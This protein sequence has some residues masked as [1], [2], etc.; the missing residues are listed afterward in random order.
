METSILKVPAIMWIL[1][2]GLYWIPFA[3]FIS[4]IE[5]FDGFL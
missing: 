3:L 4:I 1:Y 2:L 5:S